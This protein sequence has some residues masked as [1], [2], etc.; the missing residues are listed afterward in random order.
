MPN[1]LNRIALFCLAATLGAAT[2]VSAQLLTSIYSFD[3]ATNDLNL[4]AGLLLSGNT[5]Y[6]TAAGGALPNGGRSAEP[7]S[8][9]AVF[10][11]NTDGSGF[12]NLYIFSSASG[13]PASP[14][15]TNTDGANL[16]YAPQLVSSGNRL[17][18]TTDRGGFYADGTVFA[19]NTDGSG[20]TN[21]HNFTTYA[22]IDIETNGDGAIP[23]S[24]LVLSGNTLYGL[25]AAGGSSGEGTAFAINTDG[26]GFTN[27]YNFNSTNGNAGGAKSMILSGNTIYG[28][29]ENDGASMD[30]TVFSLKTDGTGIYKFTCL[31]E[32]RS[33]DDRSL[34]VHK[35][36]WSKSEGRLGFSGW[37]IVWNG[38]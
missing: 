19:I 34:C 11:L 38:N 23:C 12:T 18:G 15:I 21:L 1:Q 5:L 27:L 31:F 37:Q 35:Q 7:V 20:F 17:Y 29:T 8:G 26:T 6:G 24:G 25:T 3:N 2:T 10:K 32:P 22:S 16:A 36:R 13:S 28:T 30:G 9:G 4:T 14:Y 33:D